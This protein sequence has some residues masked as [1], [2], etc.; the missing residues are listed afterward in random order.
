MAGIPPPLFFS[1]CPLAVLD[2]AGGLIRNPV[3]ARRMDHRSAGQQKGND[4]AEDAGMN[5]IQ[6]ALASERLS[7]LLFPPRADELEKHRLLLNVLALVLII[8]ILAGFAVNSFLKGQI[9]IGAGDISVG[10]IFLA[11]LV[12]LKNAPARTFFFRIGMGILIVFLLYM[13]WA[14]IYS[15]ATI[16]WMYTMPP[17]IFFL[18]GQNEGLI[19]VSLGGTLSALLLIWPESFGTY[20]YV[21]HFRIRF[22]IS[23]AIVSLFSYW[24]ETFRHLA[25]QRELE[26]KVLLEKAL[27]EIRLLKGILPI[28]S[29]CKQ[30]RDQQGNWRQLEAYFHEQGEI[31]FSHGVCPDCAQKY[32]PN[33][34]D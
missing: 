26:K 10:C 20:P 6:S 4:E 5:L 34:I 28:C 2:M 30:I 8:A 22:L 9:L 12:C 23:F 11:G 1:N 21:D 25:H 3:Q 24:V 15:G 31:D 18:L 33:L 14:G 32:Y 19:W 17:I 13:A 29:F 7:R 27:E 16:L